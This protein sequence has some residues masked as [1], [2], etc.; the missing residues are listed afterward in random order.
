MAVSLL[1]TD[2]DIRRPEFTEVIGHSYFSSVMGTR[3]S[4]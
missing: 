1:E 2:Y 4:R 3:G